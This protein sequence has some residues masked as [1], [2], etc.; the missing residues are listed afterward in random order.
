MGGSTINRREVLASGFALSLLAPGT[1]ASRIV[2]VQH[3]Q[4]TALHCFVADGRDATALA[5]ADAVSAR[6]AAVIL[7]G[8]DLTPLYAALDEL[9]RNAPAPV[10]GVTTTSTA[11]ALERLALHHGLRI[12]YR[13]EPRDA[14]YLLTTR[15]RAR[16]L[17]ALGPPRNAA[18]RDALVFWLFAPKRA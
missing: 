5:A 8:A 10:A 17:R 9:W 15:K 12:A 13:G 14:D 2:S 3:G 11:F 7:A 16:V 4:R 6:G 18:D 1:A